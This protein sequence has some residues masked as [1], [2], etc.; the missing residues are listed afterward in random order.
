MV[1]GSLEGV[2]LDGQKTRVGS[3]WGFQA[4]PTAGSAYGIFQKAVNENLLRR[5][6]SLVLLVGLI[7]LQE[8]LLIARGPCVT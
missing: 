7:L 1:G 2:L 5:S 6:A 4:L 8:E 3:A